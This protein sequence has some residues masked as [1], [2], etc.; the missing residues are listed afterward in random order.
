M[1]RFIMDLILKIISKVPLIRDLI[2]WRIVNKEWNKELR[3]PSF[4]EEHLKNQEVTDKFLRGSCMISGSYHGILCVNATLS[5]DLKLVCLWNPS[6][7][8]LRELPQPPLE[9]Q[10]HMGFG[11]CKNNYKV[12]R[13]SKSTTR[14]T[15]NH[16][17][18]CTG[19]FR[20]NENRWIVSLDQFTIV[21]PPET[22]LDR[23]GS[24]HCD[25]RPVFCKN[26]LNWILNLPTSGHP[27][28]T[29]H[30]GLPNTIITF[31]IE[32]EE[33]N[34]MRSPRPLLPHATLAVIENQLSILTHSNDSKSIELWIMS[35]YGVEE[36]WNLKHNI[37]HHVS[38]MKRVFWF[39]ESE[40]VVS[41][42]ESV[43]Q[44]RKSH[45]DLVDKDDEDE[46]VLSLKCDEEYVEEVLSVMN[47]LDGID[48][49]KAR[50][51]NI[52]DVELI[53]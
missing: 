24:F 6:L 18:M 15:N 8:K 21:V 13:L 29:H 46:Q 31:D 50:F 26:N 44:R 47:L 5:D 36:S 35:S 45:D 10:F 9:L 32:E 22:I 53:D 2:R 42:K 3:E 23:F 1:A 40:A 12:V 37:V 43:K 7:N 49:V 16:I 11:S 33:L 51:R 14:L 25:Q 17:S 28:A 30:R 41:V 19:V 20:F 52:F 39:S 48:Q 27:R 38:A 4:V 34:F